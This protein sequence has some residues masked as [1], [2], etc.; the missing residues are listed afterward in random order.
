MEDG[1]EFVCSGTTQGSLYHVSDYPG[2]VIGESIVQGE[3]YRS[4][5]M[6]EVIQRLDWVEGASGEN[7]LFNRVIG[8]IETPQG[9]CWAY[10]YNYTE[11]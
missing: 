8:K 4:T 5:D 6:F 10:S 9:D 2:L 3:L 11:V 1:C 7:P